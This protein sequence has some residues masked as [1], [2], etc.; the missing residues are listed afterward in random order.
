MPGLRAARPD[1]SSA[2]NLNQIREPFIWLLMRILP[3]AMVPRDLAARGWADASAQA[4]VAPKC[5]GG[6]QN[7]ARESVHARV[8]QFLWLATVAAAVGAVD[9]CFDKPRRTT[10]FELSLPSGHPIG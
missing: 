2:G 6:L 4:V 10:R 3:P 7:V 8:G 5:A 9:R 1:P